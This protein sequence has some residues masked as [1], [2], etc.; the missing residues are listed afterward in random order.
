MTNAQA[1][2][3]HDQ[4]WDLLSN[5]ADIRDELEDALGSIH[6]LYE[7]LEI[8]LEQIGDDLYDIEAHIDSVS[9]S[10]RRFQCVDTQNNAVSKQE[11]TQ[12]ELPWN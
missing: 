2:L 5:Y 11:T 9:G 8:A 7:E 4:I 12:E 10:L 3:I 1:K 6:L